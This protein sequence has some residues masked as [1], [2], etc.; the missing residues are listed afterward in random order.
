[1]M[2]RRCRLPVCSSTSRRLQVAKLSSRRP[3][4]VKIGDLE[5]LRAVAKRE[6]LVPTGY[7]PEQL[8]ELPP[9]T[10]RHLRWM[11]QKD[12]L[13]LQ[14]MFLIGSAGPHKRVLAQQY[15]ELLNR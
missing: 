3:R 14:D 9:K 7:L 1:M 4:F 6:E 10:L 11:L 13:L 2:L 8:S 15:C 5:A 12:R